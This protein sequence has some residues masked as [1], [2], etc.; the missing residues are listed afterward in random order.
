[1]TRRKKK[2][3]LNLSPKQGGRAY[4]VYQKL[5]QHINKHVYKQPTGK[6]I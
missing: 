6:N 5:S 1:M 2:V 4:H 3:H